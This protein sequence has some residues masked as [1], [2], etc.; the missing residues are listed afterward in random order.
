MQNYSESKILITLDNY[1]DQDYIDN[2]VDLLLNQKLSDAQRDTLTNSVLNIINDVI[3]EE[4]TTLL[5]IL[6]RSD[7]EKAYKYSRENLE[8][9]FNLLRSSNSYFSQMLFCIQRFDK[10]TNSLYSMQIEQN[11]RYA[12]DLLKTYAEERKNQ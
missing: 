11:M 10:F 7:E 12:H 8:K 6:S 5:F 4:R 9:A 3:P 1:K 2:V